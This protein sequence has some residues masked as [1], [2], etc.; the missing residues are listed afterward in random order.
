MIGWLLDTNVIAELVS[1]RGDPR[2]LAWAASQRERT[3]FLSVLT[4]G[5]YDKG[6]HNLAPDDSARTRHSAALAALEQ[7]FAD[8]VLS[9]NDAVVRRWGRISGEIKR[10]SG[11]SP[12]VVDT[13][14]AATAI[15]HRL[16][17][18]TRNVRHVQGTGAAIFNPWTDDPIDHPLELP[19]SYFP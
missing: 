4:L 14:L 15:E 12:S 8:R 3:F 7:R 13:L 19:S 9:V 11:H 16:Y 18:V 1:R 17:L 5:E 6:I 10:M 2:V